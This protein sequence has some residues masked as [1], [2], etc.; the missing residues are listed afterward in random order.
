MYG[1]ACAAIVSLRRLSETL[2]KVVVK[3]KRLLRMK[4]GDGAQLLE[5]GVRVGVDL[6]R[7]EPVGGRPR[8]LQPV[9]GDEQDDAVACA[10]LASTHGGPQSAE[11]HTGSGLAEDAARLCEQRHVRAD[12]VLGD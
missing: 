8:R 5:Q 9:A 3:V 4:S 7:S 10:K 6:D 11:R 2:P 12:L 1:L